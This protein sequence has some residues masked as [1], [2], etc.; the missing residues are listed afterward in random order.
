MKKKKKTTK[1][2]A[3]LL[4][5]LEAAIALVKQHSF[6]LPESISWAKRILNFFQANECINNPRAF[7]I[8]R[9]IR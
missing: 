2:T 4:P 8:S 3:D 9:T 6:Q 5:S 7:E 1:S